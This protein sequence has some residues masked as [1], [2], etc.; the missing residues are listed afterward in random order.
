LGSIRDNYLALRERLDRALERCGRGGESVE[1]V[2]VTKNVGVDRIEEAARAGLTVFGENRVQEAK[3]KVGAI[4]GR[5]VSWH[6]VGHLQRNKAR[7]ALSLFSLIHSLDSLP[8]AVE[9]SKRAEGPVDL[10]LQV[11]TTG[12]ETKHGVAPHDV[13]PFLERIEALPNIRIRGLMTIAPFTDDTRR[14]RAAFRTLYR[15]FE[16]AGA[17]ELNQ[18]E[19]R[20]LSMGMTGDFEIA[21]EEGSNMIR[22]GTALFGPRKTGGGPH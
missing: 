9:I 18:T 22:V 5:D 21:V 17:L 7:A 2:A 3:G 14:V 20:F 19:M 16:E 1:I 11:N 15:L 13:K 8:L 12:E 4:R 6:M 10:L